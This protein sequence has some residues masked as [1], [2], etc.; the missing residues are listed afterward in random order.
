ME[1]AL[2]RRVW[3]VHVCAE[4]VSACGALMSVADQFGV[5]NA[6]VVER[7][8][9]SEMEEMQQRGVRPA[10]KWLLLHRYQVACG[11]GD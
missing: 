11:G 4:N 8:V 2:Q 7:Y 1:S 6:H 9:Y 3:S 5:A 10:A